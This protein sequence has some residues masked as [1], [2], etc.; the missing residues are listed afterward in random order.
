MAA[1]DSTITRGGMFSHGSIKP[2]ASFAVWRAAS[3]GEPL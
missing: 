3:V 1:S 2:A